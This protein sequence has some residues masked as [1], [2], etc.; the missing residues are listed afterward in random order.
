MLSL[1][2]GHVRQSFLSRMDF[3]KAEIERKQKQLQQLKGDRKYVKRG[4]IEKKRVEEYWKEQQALE[5]E[6]IAKKRKLID[7]VVPVE[8]KLKEMIPTEQEEMPVQGEVIRRLR[9]RGLP[10]RLFGESDDQ[11]WKRLKDAESSEIKALGQTNELKSLLKVTDTVLAESSA[12]GDKV[13]Q[14]E[15]EIQ[16]DTSELNLV[17]YKKNPIYATTL[18]IIYFK[19]LLAEWAKTLA[20]RGEDEKRTA[21]GRIQAATQAQSVQYMKPLFKSL[22]KQKLEASIVANLVEIADLTQRREYMKA[23]DVYMR[24]SIGNAPWPIGITGIGVHAREGDDL[25][26]SNRIA[27]VLNDETKRKWIQTVKRLI[28]FAQSIWPPSDLAKRVG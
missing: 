28:T 21:Q 5:Q 23:N 12:K 4:D 2:R 1:I 25:I 13:E 11:R 10:I 14:E 24:L 3:L 27:H 16:V 19:K 7:A 8:E 20:A 26:D 9:S 17:L 22:K 15:P 18:L 6:R